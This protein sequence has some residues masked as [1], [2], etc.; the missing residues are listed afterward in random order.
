MLEDIVTVGNASGLEEES[1]QVSSLVNLTSPT[2]VTAAQTL[3][4]E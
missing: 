1:D 3:Q 2:G 4:R